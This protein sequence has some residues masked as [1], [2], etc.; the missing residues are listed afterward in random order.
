MVAAVD[1]SAGHGDVAGR[2]A[3]GAV[4]E[5]EAETEVGVLTG[6]IGGGGSASRYSSSSSASA[7]AAGIE[8]VV[9]Q[10]GH[11]TFLP[12]PRSGAG[13]VCRSRRK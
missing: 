1:K 8:M 4:A 10:A 11:G 6:A 13:T 3:R 9:L 2:G 7:G 5:V 12:V